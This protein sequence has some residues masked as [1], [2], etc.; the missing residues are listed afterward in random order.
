MQHM[1]HVTAQIPCRVY[2]YIRIVSVH[3]HAQ[4]LC[5]VGHPDADRAQ[6]HDTQLLA[7]DLRTGEILLRLLG[8]PAYIL[9]IL[10]LFD[11]LD[12]AHHVAGSQQHPG[13]HKLLNAVGIGARRV[14]DDDSLLGAFV[15][16]NVVHA[17]PCPGDRQQVLRQLH[18]MHCGTPDQNTVGFFHFICLLVPVRKFLQTDSRNG[19]Q[20]MIFKHPYILFSFTAPPTRLTDDF[21]LQIPS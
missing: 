10:V 21:S 7:F 18:V 2:G 12:A 16:R 17:G 6:A 20:A 15:Q 11:P 3:F 8:V 14:E 9:I 19:I 1:L 13:D 4:M 5:H